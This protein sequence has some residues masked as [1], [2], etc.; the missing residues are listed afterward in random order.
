MTASTPLVDGAV[1]PAAVTVV[2]PTHRRHDMLPGAIGSALRQT[3]SDLEV[4]VCVDGD[5]PEGADIARSTGDARVRVLADGQRRG[6]AMNTV[7]GIREGVAPCFAVLH[8][9]DEWEPELL[10]ALLPPLEADPTLALAFGDHW[11]MDE[12]GT[13]DV[14]ASDAASAHHGR[15]RLPE[16]THRP[17]YRLTLIDQAVPPVMTTVYRRTAVDLE[18]VPVDLPANFDYWLAWLAAKGGDG[19]FF[20]PRRLSRYRVHSGQGTR[21]LR[22]SWPEAEVM[23]M[24]RLLQEPEI[25]HLHPLLRRR[26]AVAFRQRALH[27][28]ALGTPGA[29][30]S[31]LRSLQARPS[32]KGLVT[33][34][35]TCVPR[36][37]LP[38][39]AG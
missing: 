17:F 18:Q 39:A 21:V 5:D 38:R 24:T 37:A 25:A 8:D 30:S 6:E 19:A 29:R 2:I 36:A 9:D 28:H 23:M 31:A 3:R 13:V 15:A 16:G 10:E 12:V 27:R 34:V 32:G 4:V 35:L 22:T 11:V 1:P 20:V 7:R 14:A 26:L 33:L